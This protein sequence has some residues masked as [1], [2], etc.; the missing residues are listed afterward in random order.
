[1]T[2]RCLN[3]IRHKHK[4][5]VVDKHNIDQLIEVENDRGFQ[6][7]GQFASSHEMY[8]VILEELDEFW[9]SVKAN[10]PDPAELL[11]IA[12]LAKRGVL[13]L[14]EAGRYETSNPC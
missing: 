1:M 9:A 11:Q 2:R 3:K 14:C 4:W 8:A 10:D 7:H 12:A 13:E 6:A 5:L